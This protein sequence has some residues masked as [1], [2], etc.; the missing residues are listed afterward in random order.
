[1]V[2]CRTVL[3]AIAAQF[4]MPFTSALSN[5]VMS[6]V[7]TAIAAPCEPTIAGAAIVVLCSTVITANESDVRDVSADPVRTP[8]LSH[9]RMRV[10]EALAAHAKATRISARSGVYVAKRSRM[11]TTSAQSWSQMRH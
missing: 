5:G 3:S 2:F 7:F 11:A 8:S 1:M 9:R 4:E 6:H 10:A